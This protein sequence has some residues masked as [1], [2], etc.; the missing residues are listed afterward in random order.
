M[1]RF[2]SLYKIVDQPQSL[3][4]RYPN[5]FVIQPGELH[6]FP[7]QLGM[8]QTLVV[9]VGHVADTQDHSLRIWISALPNGTA[10][11]G[12][13]WHANR[14]PVRER[15]VLTTS[16]NG[17]GLPFLVKTTPGKK[18]LNILNLINSKNAYELTFDP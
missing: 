14:P 3:S 7:V 13:I 10:L 18:Y 17:D 15:T 9:T 8:E 5:R 2:Q 12:I 11:A 4:T 16:V 1:M 6:L